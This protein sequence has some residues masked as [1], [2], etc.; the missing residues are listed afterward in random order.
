MAAIQKECG[1][2]VESHLK[3]GRVGFTEVHSLSEYAGRSVY[4]EECRIT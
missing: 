1:E 4:F 3:D 2:A